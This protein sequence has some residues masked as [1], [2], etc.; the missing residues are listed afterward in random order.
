MTSFFIIFYGTKIEDEKMK[1]YTL[2]VFMLAF[3]LVASSV[4]AVGLSNGDTTINFKPNLEVVIPFLVVNVK[5]GTTV[6]LSA[7]GELKDY[8]TLSEMDSSGRFNAI[9]NLPD[10]IET[11]GTHTVLIRAEEVSSTTQGTVSTVTAAQVP[12]RIKV[13]YPGSYMEMRFDVSDVKIGEP[14]DF[15]VSVTNL[16]EKDATAKGVIEIYN[17]DNEKV[18]TV[19][20]EEKTIETTKTEKLYALWETNNIKDGEYRAVATVTYEGKSINAEKTFRIGM[21]AINIIDC[22]KEFQKDSISPI[23]IEIESGWNDK[24]LDVYA[25]ITITG[26]N[27]IRVA[28]FKTPNTDVNPWERKTISTYWNTSGIGDDTY[29][30]VITLHYAGKVT[31]KTFK[32]SSEETFKTSTEEKTEVTPSI[33]GGVLESM[34]D[35]IPIYAIIIICTVAVIAFYLYKRRD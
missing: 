25:E 22:T 7:L 3:S 20:T 14:V 34:R 2:I 15:L 21:F 8:V 12:I 27:K 1:I 24:I 28:S 16:G 18:A 29:D 5:N 13:P 31:E 30:A 10:K 9:V 26:S 23:N 35:S 32:I 17:P 11:P 33:T 19:D 6:R 4:F